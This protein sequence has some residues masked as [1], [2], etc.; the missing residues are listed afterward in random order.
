M[1]WM[2]LDRGR[3]KDVRLHA[4]LRVIL[5]FYLAA[6]MLVYGGGKLIPDQFPA[7][8]PDTLVRPVGDLLPVELLWTFMGASSAYTIFTGVA[9][10]VGGLLLTAR[11]TTLLGALICAGVLGNVFML[12]VAYD[13]PVKILSFHLMAMSVF[14]V[15][16]DLSRLANLLLLNRPAQPAT[17]RPLFA[18]PWRSSSRS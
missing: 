2:L 8:P 6:A 13:V 1:G 14:L 18:R 12:N 9:E 15:A 3:G 4:W 7:P 10:M 11:R 17:L 16:P 5:R